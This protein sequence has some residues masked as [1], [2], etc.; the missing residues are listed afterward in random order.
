MSLAFA[1]F[2]CGNSKKSSSDMNDESKVLKATIGNTDKKSDAVEINSVSID[3]NIMTLKVSFSG[4]CEGH[5][6]ELIGSEM[7]MKSLPGKRPVAL[8]HNANGDMCE[9]YLTEEIQFDISELAISKENGSQ[10]YLI[11]GKEEY[12]YT[13][14]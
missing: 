1:L 11:L 9:A 4:G 12:L 2:S 13:Y 8:I 3:G 6:F 7:V 10:I 5:Q 14:K